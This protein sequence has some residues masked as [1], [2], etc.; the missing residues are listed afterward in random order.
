[1]TKRTMVEKYDSLQTQQKEMSNLQLLQFEMLVACRDKR[2]R[3][4]T[5]ARTLNLLQKTHQNQRNL[6]KQSIW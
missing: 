2:M 1:M 4:S 5:H 3:A 6:K